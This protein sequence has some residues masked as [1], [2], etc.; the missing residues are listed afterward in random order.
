MRFDCNDSLAKLA[1]INNREWKQCDI[2]PDVSSVE[3]DDEEEQIKA[4]I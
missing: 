2:S 3:R 4:T 1:R